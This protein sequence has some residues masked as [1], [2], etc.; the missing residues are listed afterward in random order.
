M[1]YDLNGVNLS[2]INDLN[3]NHN[4][5]LIEGRVIKIM[6]TIRIKIKRTSVHALKLT[7]FLYDPKKSRDPTWIPTLVLFEDS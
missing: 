4:L 7:P 6:I 1:L 5:N 3:H 2:M